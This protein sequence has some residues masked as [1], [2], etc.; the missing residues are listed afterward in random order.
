[1]VKLLEHIRIVLTI[2]AT[3]IYLVERPGEGQEKKAEVIRLFKE[4]LQLL[5][6]GKLI[7]AWVALIFGNNLFLGW[8]IDLIVSLANRAQIFETGGDTEAGQTGGNGEE[9]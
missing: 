3:L 5:V 6:E 9:R 4:E 8:I 1:M 2:L 7:P